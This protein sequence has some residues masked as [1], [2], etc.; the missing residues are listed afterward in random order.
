MLILIFLLVSQTLTFKVEWDG[1]KDGTPRTYKL[2]NL[3][4]VKVFWES[5]DHN[6]TQEYL[7]VPLTISDIL[8]VNNAKIVEANA[9]DYVPDG[10]IIAFQVHGIKSLYVAVV[11]DEKNYF[12]VYHLQ[13]CQIAHCENGLTLIPP[14]NEIPKIFG[15]EV[16]KYDDIIYVKYI[17]EDMN[18]KL[19]VFQISGDDFPLVIC[20]YKGWVSIYSGTEFIPYEETNGIMYDQFRHRQIILPAYPR[21]DDTDVFVCGSIKYKDG[22]QLTISYKMEVENYYDIKSNE[23]INDIEAIWKCSESNKISDNYY[24]LYSKNDKIRNKMKYIKYDSRDN[25]KFY[26]NDTMYIYKNNDELKML[27]KDGYKAHENK[28]NFTTITPSCKRTLPQLKFKLKLVSPDGTNTFDSKNETKILDVTEDMLNKEL[29]YKCKIFVEEASNHPFLSN[30][31]DDVMEVSLVSKDDDGNT[32]LHDT[33]MFK[34][35]FDGF[36][37]YEC[38][39]RLKDN[40]FKYKYATENLSFIT[41]PSN[42]SIKNQ[43][44]EWRVKEDVVIQCQRRLSN[45]GEIDRIKVEVPESFLVEYSNLTSNGI[46]NIEGDYV[47]ANYDN[48]IKSKGKKNGNIKSITTICI[49]KALGGKLLSIFKSGTILQKTIITQKVNKSNQAK[50]KREKVIII[51]LS[52]GIGILVLAIVIAITTIFVVR[53]LNK[54]GRK[55]KNSSLS[56]S[57][58]FSSYANS[59]MSGSLLSGSGLSTSTVRKSQSNVS[60]VNK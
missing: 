36:K 58:S 44:E 16:N 53:C 45:I 29:N 27:K 59:S 7:P 54:R 8:L 10:N 17:T 50:K 51:G 13:T 19:Y 26:Y 33:I 41:I 55:G 2:F 28:I 47:R 9:S 22:S 39:I 37:K 31:Y 57:S 15:P 6:T 52:V 34:D 49:Y 46:F 4:S 35:N 14:T 3:Q 5:Q 23:P 38:E 24:F 32:I 60:G 48:L 11:Y 30:Y 42:L 40:N 43:S 18:L 12:N 20:P 21:N 25:A 56:I 1:K